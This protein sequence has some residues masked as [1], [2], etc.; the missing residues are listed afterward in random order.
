MEYRNVQF[1][2]CEHLDNDMVACNVSASTGKE[3]VSVDN[4]EL[5]GPSNTKAIEEFVTNTKDGDYIL[6][7][8]NATC[9]TEFFGDE[10]F[11]VC[12]D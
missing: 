3:H 12:E 2:E 7:L 6:A 4:I 11:L 5:A 10:K 1:L 8:D 9:K